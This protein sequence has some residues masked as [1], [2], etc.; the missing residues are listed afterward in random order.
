MA[1]VVLTYQ[2]KLR[3]SIS[4]MLI[5]WLNTKKTMKSKKLHSKLLKYLIKH[6]YSTQ[7]IMGIFAN[8]N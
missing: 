1:K 2:G 5:K 7:Y 3:H 4:K 6:G 8:R